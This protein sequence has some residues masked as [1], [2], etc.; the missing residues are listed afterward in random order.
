MRR[1][2]LPA[3]AIGLAVVASAAGVAPA[4]FAAQVK[5]HIVVTQNGAAA[6][7]PIT[8]VSPNSVSAT[9]TVGLDGNCL[10]AFGHDNN[11]TFGIAAVSDNAAVATVAPDSWPGLHCGQT[12]D[13]VITG[14]SDGSATISFDAV[15]NT[16][17]QKQTAGKSF[18]VNVSGFG[19]PNPTP[20]PEGHGK[21]APPAVANAHV[22]HGSALADTCKAHY[23][24]AKNWH[25]LLIRDIAKWA[26][27]NKLNQNKDSY[28]DNDWLAMI[29]AHVDALCASPPS[30]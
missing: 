27:D 22:P 2:Q 8:L 9:V 13:F 3:A 19:T 17:L 16:G 11:Q 4:A 5:T 30:S 6:T 18:T 15:A 10:E 23:A 24:G 21:P 14:H 12:H 28:S 7:S 20:N 29:T 1:L 26:R 25:G